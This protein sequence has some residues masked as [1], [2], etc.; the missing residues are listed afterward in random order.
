MDANLGRKLYG[1]DQGTLAHCT[2]W[3]IDNMREE[4]REMLE[5]MY[6]EAAETE[7][8]VA[9]GEFKKYAFI[10]V[11][12]LIFES[13]PYLTASSRTFPGLFV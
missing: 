9:A 12:I 6:E 7:E 11:A 8:S 3:W 2:L 10:S 5:G 4:H 13:S 1:K